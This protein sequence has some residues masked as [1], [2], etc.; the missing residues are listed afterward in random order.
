M[1]RQRRYIVIGGVV[2]LTVVVTATLMMKRLLGDANVDGAD[3]P[4]QRLAPVVLV[5]VSIIVLGLGIHKFPS[6]FN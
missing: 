6:R 5:V 4:A 3:K 1:T 2:V